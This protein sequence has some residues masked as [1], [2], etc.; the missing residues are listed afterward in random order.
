MSGRRVV[1]GGEVSLRAKSTIK[2]ALLC[3]SAAAAVVAQTG[4]SKPAEDTLAN[5][6]QNARAMRDE[7]QLNLLKV[8][9]E[10]RIGE[11]NCDAQCYY[12]AGGVQ[13]YLADACELRKDKKAASA[14]TDHGIELALYSLQL[15]EKSADTHALLGDLYAHKITYGVA[16]FTGPKFGPKINDEIAK[17]M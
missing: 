1:A 7:A 6:V 14:A 15:N 12:E 16:M 17:G 8:E 4:V 9:F 13:L 5:R 2:Y 11:S 10:K 3:M